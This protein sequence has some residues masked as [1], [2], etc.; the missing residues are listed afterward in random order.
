MY[1]FNVTFCVII[2]ALFSIQEA[3]CKTL[4]SLIPYRFKK[5]IFLKNQFYKK[6]AKYFNNKIFEVFF[7]P[8]QYVDNFVRS[9][10]NY[11][12]ILLHF[13]NS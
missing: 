8:V 5:S 11:G 3:T 6:P 2:S 7:L 1:C 13:S 9:I 4:E 12:N 10:L